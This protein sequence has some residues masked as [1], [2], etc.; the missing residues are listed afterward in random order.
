MGYALVPLV[1]PQ[2]M[3]NGRRKGRRPFGYDTTAHNFI[4]L[5]SGDKSEPESGLALVWL[6]T[7]IADRRVTKIADGPDER[8]TGQARA[9]LARW[10]GRAFNASA[11]FNVQIAAALGVTP[12]ANGDIRVWL[13]PGGRG[14]NVF[15]SSRVPEGPH[16][17]AWADT[18][19]RADGALNGSTLSGGGATWTASGWAVFSNTA[20]NTAMTTDTL[21]TAAVDTDADTDSEYAQIDLNTFTP[22][23]TSNVL[24]TLVATNWASDGS[25]GYGFQQIYEAASEYRQLFSF[26]EVTLDED[27]A[28]AVTTGTMLQRR[29]GTSLEGFIGGVSVLGPVTVNTQASGTGNR[30]VG[31]ATYYFGSVGTPTVV[32]D[33]FLGGDIVTATTKH[34]ALLGIG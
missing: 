3:A 12:Q 6:E 7:D 1:Q 25:S 13:G 5:D 21:D 10:S 8:L 15:Y 26:D 2:P 11:P 24:I 9:A 31:F 18:F 22:G 34:L 4:V 17:K 16:S 20:R 14:R 28:T 29:N 27:L 33:N 32:V 23:D 19:N 30:R